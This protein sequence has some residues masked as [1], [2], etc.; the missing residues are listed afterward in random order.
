MDELMGTLFKYGI[1]LIGL[2]IVVWILVATLG[3]NKA[4]TE[5]ANMTQLA[6]S[7]SNTY[8]GQT[9]FTGLTEAVAADIAPTSMV[10][11]A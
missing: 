8:S 1:R 5:V 7:I 11:G 3:K 2:G 6:T 10:S 9:T 4:A